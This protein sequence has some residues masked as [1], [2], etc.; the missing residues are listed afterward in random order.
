MPPECRIQDAGWKSTDPPCRS[1]LSGPARPSS[2]PPAGCAL[3]AKPLSTNR[4]QQG[5]GP[6]CEG[7]RAMAGGA[8]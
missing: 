4:L 6:P 7:G 1:A 8:S 2:Q 3:R 5:A